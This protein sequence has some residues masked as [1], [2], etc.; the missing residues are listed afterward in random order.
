VP[1]ILVQGRQRAFYGVAFKEAF[2]DKRGAEFQTWFAKI[3]GHA[4]G[5]E[6]LPHCAFLGET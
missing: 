1:Q 5:A 6:C 2:I 3:A 4:Y